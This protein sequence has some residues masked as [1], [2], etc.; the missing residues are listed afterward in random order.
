MTHTTAAQ[1][2]LDS[3]ME[4][5]VRTG[6][7]PV[8]FVILAGAT[9][10]GKTQ[11]ALGAAYRLLGEYARNDVLVLYDCSR[12]LEK[13]HVIKISSDE[14]ITRADGTVVQDR[15]IREVHQWIAKS[16]AGQWKVLVIEHI[17]RLNEASANAL[18]KICEEPLPHR[19]ILA[20]TS[21][22]EWLLTT[23]LS[24]AL[25]F[26]CIATAYDLEKSIG[27]GEIR[28]RVHT[29]VHKLFTKDAH[30][31]DT[32]PLV[33]AINKAWYAKERLLAVSQYAAQQQLRDKVTLAHTSY[34][35]LDMS[36]TTDHLLFDFL[37]QRFA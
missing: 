16:A 14:V 27:D 32:Y 5:L 33:V 1:E 37:L 2:M 9:G 15:G 29:A 10:S 7:A 17:D 23:I 6:K 28:D 34:G 24:R 8:P 12:E 19:L 13:P 25:V 30:L 18:L 36:I 11:M 22:K 35:M 26:S 4:K 20:T 21:Q 31:S 3:F